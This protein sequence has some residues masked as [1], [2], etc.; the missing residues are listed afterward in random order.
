MAPPTPGGLDIVVLFHVGGC[1]DVLRPECA[2]GAAK[3]IEDDAAFI[4]TPHLV[5]SP[6]SGPARARRVEAERRVELLDI[7]SAPVKANALTIP[8]EDESR[9]RMRVESA[10][11]ASPFEPLM[12]SNG[13]VAPCDLLRW[14]TTIA[15]RKR[16]ASAFS[17]SIEA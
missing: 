14:C 5:G 1:R 11:A 10:Q 2:A 4:R 12:R 3:R 6:E 16:S 13:S 7:T 9:A 17:G 8:V 15:M